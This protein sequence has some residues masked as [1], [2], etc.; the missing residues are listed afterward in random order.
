MY[1]FLIKFLMMTPSY[2]KNA[3]YAYTNGIS[4]YFQKKKTGLLAKRQINPSCHCIEVV[5]CFIKRSIPFIHLLRYVM[6]L[7]SLNDQNN[8][9]VV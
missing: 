8:Y 6:K 2:L 4:V 3:K 9:F 1:L 5:S 7:F